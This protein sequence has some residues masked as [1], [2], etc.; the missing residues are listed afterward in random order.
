[1]SSSTRYLIISSMK[2]EASFILE[3]VAYHRLIGFTDFL[4]YTND[5]DDGT[6]E[7][8]ERLEALGIVKHEANVVLRRGPHK[9]ALKAAK[10]HPLTTAADWTLVCDIDEF[11]LVNVGDGSVGALIDRMPSDTDVIPIT[12]RLFGNNDQIA[13]Q[14]SLVIEQFTDAEKSLENDGAPDRFVK[15]LFRRQRD[16]ERLGIHGPRGAQHVVWRQPDG[17]KLTSDDNLTRPESQFAYEVAQIN[18]YAV[19]SIDGFLVK[20]DRGRANHWKHDLGLDYWQ[21]LCRGGERDTAILKWLDQTKRDV[22][23]LLEDPDLRR[24]HENAVSW[25]Q[26][27]IVALRND[28]RFEELRSKIVALSADLGTAGHPAQA[29]NTKAVSAQNAVRTRLETLC[30]EMRALMD[31]LSP[32]D[33][34]ELAHDRLDDIERGLFGRVRNE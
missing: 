33:Q 1:M 25:R 24:L 26:D 27:R 8:L 15:S 23:T 22:A 9:S 11:L 10:D 21:R 7:M 29:L 30:S 31:Q 16:I 6:V 13:F 28:P 5:C 19:G 17:R 2:N 4:I 20:K 3:W 34:A 14:D 32:H 18:H 12:W